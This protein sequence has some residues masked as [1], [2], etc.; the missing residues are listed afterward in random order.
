MEIKEFKKWLIEIG[1]DDNQLYIE[2]M[3]C[4]QIEAYKASFL[5]SYLAFMNHIKN[6][7]LD[8]SGVPK[9][10]SSSESDED[11]RLNLWTKRIQKLENEDMWENET[12]NF[13]NE[14]ST[15]NIFL[16]KDDIRNEFLQKRGLRN[17][18]AHNKQRMIDCSTV[19]DLWSFL[20]YSFTYFVVDGSVDVLKERFIKSQRYLESKKHKKEC[21]EIYKIYKKLKKNDQ[22]NF[23]TW[24]TNEIEKYVE[25]SLNHGDFSDFR[26]LFLEKVFEQINAQEYKWIENT[27]NKFTFYVALT[28]TQFNAIFNELTEFREDFYSMDKNKLLLILIYFGYDEKVN[29]LLKEVF[30]DNYKN[31]WLEIVLFLASS[32]QEPYFDNEILNIIDKL[33]IIPKKIK[34]IEKLLYSYP[35]GTN[36]NEQFRKQAN[37]DYID[38]TQFFNNR[39]L[40]NIFMLQKKQN[41]LPNEVGDR[42][43]KTCK[44]IIQDGDENEEMYKLLQSNYSIYN[45]LKKS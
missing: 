43:V 42:L 15:T 16:L 20:S 24:I 34:E 6:L 37:K 45:W 35:L 5:Y 7:I 2:A 32:L 44:K 40:I 28:N 29:Y 26:T 41:I 11:K 23:F 19:E 38:S 33:Q 8:Y 25:T 30:T 14:G 17:V 39:G 1:E 13:I 12:F 21:D 10:F 31:E 4:Y 22:K 36:N 27:T 9:K 3:K 18:A